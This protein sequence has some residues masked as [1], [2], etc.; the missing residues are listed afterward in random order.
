M[1]IIIHPDNYRNTHSKFRIKFNQIKNFMDL[2]N[3]LPIIIMVLVGALAGT[4]AARI[5]KGDTFGFAINALLGIAGG[6]VGGILFDMLGFE[7]GSNVVRVL[8]DSYGLNLGGTF[9][10]QI[11]SATV[12]AIIILYVA[13]FVRGGRRAQSKR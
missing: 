7:P 13:R 4:L 9:I 3:A 2:S 5:M 6:V 11:I 12:G 10:G 8:N 1:L